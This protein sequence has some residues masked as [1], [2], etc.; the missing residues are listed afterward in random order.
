MIPL[1]L[2]LLKKCSVDIR[3]LVAY[4]VSVLATYSI[5]LFGKPADRVSCMSNDGKLIGLILDMKGKT[6]WAMD[7]GQTKP[8]KN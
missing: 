6:K 5:L 8:H 1:W 2:R 4:L 7:L 3:I